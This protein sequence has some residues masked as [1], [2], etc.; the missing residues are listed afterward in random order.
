MFND[1]IILVAAHKYAAGQCKAFF[2]TVITGIFKNVPLSGLSF[3]HDE[4]HKLWQGFLQQLGFRLATMD[5]GNFKAELGD[6]FC[7][8]FLNNHSYVDYVAWGVQD[9]SSTA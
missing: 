5:T 1:D 9:N 3:E 6:N 2:H 8:E 7:I 4:A